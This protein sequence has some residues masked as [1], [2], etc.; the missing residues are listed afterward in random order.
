MTDPLR[1]GQVGLGY[2]GRNLVRNFDDLARLTWLCDGAE[3]V[4]EEFARRYPHARVTADFEELL[5][6]DELDAVVV[7]T[8]VPTHHALAKRAL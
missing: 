1:V 5:A 4:R 7:A 3:P 2:W 6:D 8:P